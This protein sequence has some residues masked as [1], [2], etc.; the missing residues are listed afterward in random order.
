MVL[1]F[2]KE[3]SLTV[4]QPFQPGGHTAWVAPA[5][6]SLCEERVLKVA[7][8]HPQADHEVDGLHVW[9][10]SGAVQIYR[11]AEFAETIVLRSGGAV[12]GFHCPGT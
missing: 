6:T 3:W 11:A 7:W 1:R 8:R 5:L 12:P 10:G 2:S 9:A 4:D